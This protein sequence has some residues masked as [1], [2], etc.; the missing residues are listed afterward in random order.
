MRG[1]RREENRRRRKNTHV[2]LVFC[3]AQRES[4][5]KE[6]A[7]RP[8]TVEDVL[9]YREHLRSRMDGPED[10]LGGRGMPR[11]PLAGTTLGYPRDV[12]VLWKSSAP[13]VLLK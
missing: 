3:L 9:W 5:A 11:A 12:D 4:M 1:K 8:R 13:E 7:W 6:T 2:L 10:L